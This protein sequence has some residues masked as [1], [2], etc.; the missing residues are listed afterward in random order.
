MEILPKFITLHIRLDR[1]NFSFWR[2]QVLATVKAHGFEEFL[3]CDLDSVPS[4]DASTSAG[5]SSDS[6]ATVLWHRKDQF[7]L[8]WLLNLISEGMLG[9]VNRC[10]HA[11]QVWRVFDD[12]FRSQSKARVMNLKLQLQTFKKGSLS[13][14]E[15][16]LQMR[17][18]ADGLLTAGHA[19]SDDDL[20]L[21]LLGGLGPEF[22]AVVVNLTTRGDLFSLSEVQ[23]VLHMFEMRLLQVSASQTTQTMSNPT[24]NVVNK[25][26]NRGGSGNFKGKGKSYGKQRIYCQLCGKSNHI[27]AKCFKRFDKNF[28]GLEHVPSPD[29][30]HG[31]Q[32]NLAHAS[33][34]YNGPVYS[35]SIAH[36]EMPSSSQSFAGADW[37][38]DS[39][40]THHVTAS[41]GNMHIQQPYR[42]NSHLVVGNGATAKIKSVGSMKASCLQHDKSVIL[43][44]ILHV[45][46]ITKN[47]LS[48][49]QFLKDNAA[50]IEFHADFCVVK[51][52]KSN[53]IL[54]KGEL[55]DGLYQMNLDSVKRIVADGVFSVSVNNFGCKPASHPV[56]VPSSNS[57]ITSENK[58]ELW[59]RRLVFHFVML[60][61]LASCIR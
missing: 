44:N 18:F 43:S 7:L 2:N 24:A 3:F 11:F 37:Y 53:K 32:V 40:A 45:P 23:S 20:V 12:L 29:S 41:L 39:G 31:S 4:L 52:L 8:S 30:G 49:S 61:N 19:I 16:V 21:Y 22:D 1:N 33:G 35:P 28:P 26:N 36:S 42:G 51:D 9:H 47:L 57:C 14:D 50:I 10:V 25:S 27:V 46:D 58:S 13:I 34:G 56:L 48:I 60:V 55:K 17:T 54:L 15:Y 59:H 6:S 38:V 5:S